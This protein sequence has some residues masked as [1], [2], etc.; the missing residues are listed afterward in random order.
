MVAVLRLDGGDGMYR[1]V[2]HVFLFVPDEVRSDSARVLGAARP[3]RP[4]RVEQYQ[5]ASG[6]INPVAQRSS[7]VAK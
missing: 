2:A 3:D 7:P 1:V 6:F 5:P 4:G